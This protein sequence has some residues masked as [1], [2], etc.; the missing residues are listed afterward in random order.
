MND[1]PMDSEERLAQ[2]DGAVLSVMNYPEQSDRPW[3]I[4]EIARVVR[5]DPRESLARL[6]SEG[7]VHA[8]GG[9]YWPTRAAVRAE[10]I[11]Q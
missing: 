11:K 3:S 10:E 4:D 8:I 1:E 6:Q 9:F 2:V 7:L 5:H